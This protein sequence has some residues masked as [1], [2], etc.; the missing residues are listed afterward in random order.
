M[1]FLALAFINITFNIKVIF[2]YEEK[3]FIFVLEFILIPVFKDKAI[4]HTNI[5]INQ[6][7]YK[8]LL[9]IVIL[10]VIPILI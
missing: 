9:R 6:Y 2:A 8:Y 3:I 5:D 10:S 7:D 4:I 1:F